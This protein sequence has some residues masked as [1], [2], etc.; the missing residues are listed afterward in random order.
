MTTKELVHDSS[1]NF[2]GWL[3]EPS[4]IYIR[5][6]QISRLLAV[7]GYQPHAFLWVFTHIVFRLLPVIHMGCHPCLR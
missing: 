5:E 3:V 4:T 2:K 1:V 6:T 7:L